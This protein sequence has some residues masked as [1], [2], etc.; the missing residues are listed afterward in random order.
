LIEKGKILTKINGDYSKAS[1][2][3]VE[4]I[5]D[6]DGKKSGSNIWIC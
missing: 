1:E 3:Y 5:T 2:V 4:A 6:V